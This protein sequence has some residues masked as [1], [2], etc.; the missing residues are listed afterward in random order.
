MDIEKEGSIV[1]AVGRYIARGAKALV[2]SK[3]MAIFHARHGKT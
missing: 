1:R 3:L 2:V